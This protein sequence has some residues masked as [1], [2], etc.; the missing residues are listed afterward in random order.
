MG[1]LLFS[2]PVAYEKKM[3]EY[4]KKGVER[5]FPYCDYQ[6]IPKT[7]WNYG[8]ADSI[9]KVSFNGVS[10]IPFS[11]SAPAVTVKANMYQINWGFKF[12]YK[13]ICRKTPKSRTPVSGV[14]EI[15]LYPYGCSR[16]RMTE[17][18]LLG[19]K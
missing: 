14:Q 6:F 8:F 11:E 10:D 17:M 15:E 5:K 18:P 9:F 4:T 13:S 2:V 19:R 3:R 16:L 7:P 12:P 1:S